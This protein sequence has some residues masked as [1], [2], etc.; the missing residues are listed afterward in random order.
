MTQTELQIMRMQVIQEMD[1]AIIPYRTKLNA[2]DIAMHSAEPEK[3]EGWSDE[4][5]KNL[6]LEDRNRKL[7]FYRTRK[8]WQRL[9]NWQPNYS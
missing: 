8:W 3:P 1:E 7:E 5:H 9:F 4:K 6:L 2:I